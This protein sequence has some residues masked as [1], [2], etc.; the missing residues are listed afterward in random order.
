MEYRKSQQQELAIGQRS[1]ASITPHPRPSPA[2]TSF[3]RDLRVRLRIDQPRPCPPG[4]LGGAHRATCS[5]W[6]VEA[7][8]S[9][10]RLGVALRG[11]TCAYLPPAASFCSPFLPALACLMRGDW[12][13]RSYGRLLGWVPP[14]EDDVLLR[15][16]A[17]RRTHL[18]ATR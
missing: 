16:Q 11:P 3:H 10:E 4:P 13:L 17:L 12:F 9:K 7:V 8:G 14:A 2:L 1:S 5:P 18:T 15:R 6:E